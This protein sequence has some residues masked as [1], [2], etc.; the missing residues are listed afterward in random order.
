MS[1][2]DLGGYYAAIEVDYDEALGYPKFIEYRAKPNI[3]DAGA[4][5][6]VRN[7]LPLN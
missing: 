4:T 3:A 1:Q 2:S 5:I 7:V 6:E